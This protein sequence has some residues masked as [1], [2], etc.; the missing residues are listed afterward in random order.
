L[1]YQLLTNNVF[2]R[3]ADVFRGVTVQE[4]RKIQVFKAMMS[5]GSA[6]F[7]RKPW[8]ASALG[9]KLSAFIFGTRSFN[10]TDDIREAVL[11]SDAC[12]KNAY[13]IGGLDVVAADPRLI[14]GID[15]HDHV[16]DNQ[17]S[18]MI[19]AKVGSVGK[20]PRFL[21][22]KV[23]A[24]EYYMEYPLD[25]VNYPS[26]YIIQEAHQDFVRRTTDCVNT[27]IRNYVYDT[28]EEE[29]Q[30][31]K[32]G[33]TVSELQEEVIEFE[34]SHRSEI[35]QIAA[36]FQRQLG[37]YLRPDQQHLKNFENMTQRF[38]KS[39]KK[40]WDS[41]EYELIDLINVLNDKDFDDA[42][43]AKYFKTYI[44]QRKGLLFKFVGNFKTMVKSG[45]TYFCTDFKFDE[46]GR[47][48]DQDSRPRNIS[49]PDAITCGTL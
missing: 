5:I 41:Q 13:R 30:I 42:K 31:T 27:Y 26:E 17:F 49:I 45:E 24:R 40:L 6:D 38:F 7:K 25:S 15:E 4:K 32:T 22:K 43:K 46:K 34:W 3:I 28:Q 12:V 14:I 2:A 10:A 18:Q 39:F 37:S 33:Y 44:R 19:D 1:K 21:G 16:C 47:L 48:L 36:V 29:C 20:Q 23:K 9:K 11:D 8:Y 35:N